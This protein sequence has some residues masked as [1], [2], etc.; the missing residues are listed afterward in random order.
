M[1]S[2]TDWTWH[3]SVQLEGRNAAR[4]GS[5][6]STW[7]PGLA[8]IRTASARDIAHDLVAGL[9]VGLI[10]VPQAMGYALVAGL[11]PEVGL[12]TA[13][14]SGLVAAILSP[15]AYLVHG[16][17]NAISIAVFAA[18]AH[19]GSLDVHE[20]VTLAVLLSILVGLIQTA[21]GIFRAGDLTRFVS[22]GVLLGFMVAAAVLIVLTQV[23]HVLGIEAKDSPKHA[24]WLLA[25]LLRSVHRP[26]H[27]LTVL[28]AAASAVCLVL[29]RWV[30]DRLRW[31]VPELFLTMTLAAVAVWAL[32]LAQAGV[33]VVGELS[34]SLPVLR[35]P[36]LEW[37]AVERLA[38]SAL[39]IALL[40]LLE[41]LA[42]ARSL[43]LRNGEAF[44]ANQQCVS[45]GL[46]NLVGGL[47][48]C[49]PGSGSFTRSAVNYEAGAR[50]QLA[51]V[52]AA[53]SVA[54]LVLWLA[55]LARYVPL[56]TL[57]VILI[58]AAWRMIDWPALRYHLRATRVDA[59]IVLLTALAGVLISVEFAILAG[60]F[61]SVVCYV[62]RAARLYLTE[63]VVSGEGVV[64]ERRPGDLACERMVMFDLEGE[65]FFGAAPA[66]EEG[67]DAIERRIGP[68]T[69]VILLRLKRV[70]NADATCLELLHDR[71]AR[72][73]SAGLPVLLCGVRPDLAVSLRRTGVTRIIGTDALFRERPEAWSSTLEAVRYAYG[74]LDDDLCTHCPRRKCGKAEAWYY[75]I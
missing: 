56:A 20:R 68:N 65:L 39:A 57:G 62:P 46:A 4:R 54:L 63:L 33:A 52:I 49:M 73:R 48:G 5:T 27:L 23:P 38:G 22:R 7:L 18:L 51:A 69:R 30:R 75:V 9:T 14:V 17:T 3:G 26:P 58:V 12:Y 64:R 59:A 72:W 21:L 40:G 37:G 24:G 47:F 13:I 31:P 55:P 43:A 1:A 67:L 74:L 2:V 32:D 19:F 71:V 60:T 34:T 25:D 10:T 70:R 41:A 44:D 61:L 11:P 35:W 6:W 8:A 53:V 45:E 42:I 50:T 28:L 16:P 36:S 15:S 66:L 29:L